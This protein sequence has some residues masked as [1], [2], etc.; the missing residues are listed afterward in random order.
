MTYTPFVEEIRISDSKLLKDMIL[1]TF[2]S[3]V[4][5]LL[6][7]VALPIGPVPISLQSLG[8]LLIGSLY[9]SRRAFLTTS[10]YVFQGAIGL[11]VF[12][13]GTFGAAI[14]LGPTGGYLI[15]FIIAAT[16]MGFFAEKGYERSLKKSI[17]L[18]FLGHTIIFLFGLTWLSKFTGLNQSVFVLGLIPFIPGMIVKTA[19][20]SGVT[21]N[22]WKFIKKI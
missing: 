8:V 16:A 6:A 13:G 17:P 4:L 9:G 12:A 2:G 20:A 5:G 1:I 11:P 22:L 15:G 3:L 7:Q 14:L 18:F 19:I 10:F 21:P